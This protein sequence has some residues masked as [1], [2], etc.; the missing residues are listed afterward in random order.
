ML[1]NVPSELGFFKISGL[2]STDTKFPASEWDRLIPKSV[3]TL[4][5]FRNSR[6]NHNL[7]AHA[8]LLGNVDFNATPLALL[9]EY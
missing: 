9:E 1:L 8:Y 4:N 5:I 2:T 6:V 7:S 3:L